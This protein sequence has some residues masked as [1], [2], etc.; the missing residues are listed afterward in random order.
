M[1]TVSEQVTT[2]RAVR[3]DRMCDLTGS[4]R[5]SVWRRVK[6]DPSFPLRFRL[7]A[8]ITWDEAEILA[9]IEAKKATGGDLR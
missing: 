5:A 9:W 6:N 7:S 8:G 1:N 4:L 2:G 3:L